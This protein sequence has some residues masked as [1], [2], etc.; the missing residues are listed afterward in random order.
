MYKIS[1]TLYP[2]SDW[3]DRKNAYPMFDPI[4]IPSSSVHHSIISLNL[5]QNETTEKYEIEEKDKQEKY[6]LFLD[7]N[8]RGERPITSF[9]AA[10]AA[11]TKKE[12]GESI[13]AV[14]QHKEDKYFTTTV[15]VLPNTS[16]WVEFDENFHV[17]ISTIGKSE[18]VRGER[19]T[20]Q[21]WKLF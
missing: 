1:S 16:R 5:K 11:A 4:L 9:T 14:F 10:A 6:C 19:K 7:N 2:V 12:D 15:R 21:V 13:L 18:N 8:T 3:L 20:Y 17:K